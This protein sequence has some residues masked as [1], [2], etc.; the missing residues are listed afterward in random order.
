METVIVQGSKNIKLK[1][2]DRR[3]VIVQMCTTGEHQF[4]IE[5]LHRNADTPSSYFIKDLEDLAIWKLWCH[6][7]WLTNKEAQKTCKLLNDMLESDKIIHAEELQCILSEEEVANILKETD[8]N[9]CAVVKNDTTSYE[10]FAK[11]IFSKNVKSVCCLEKG[12]NGKH[13]D[14]HDDMW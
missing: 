1:N 7:R 4:R 13:K 9:N 6:P 2:E 12:H 14:K 11:R 8:T 10:L 5:F 3:F